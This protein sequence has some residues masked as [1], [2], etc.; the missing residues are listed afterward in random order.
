MVNGELLPRFRYLWTV[1][2][3]R[4]RR[5]R[6]YV[7]FDQ[8]PKRRRERAFPGYRRARRWEDENLSRFLR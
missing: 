7:L 3:F 2:P 6:H 4:R 5:R 8:V 1:R